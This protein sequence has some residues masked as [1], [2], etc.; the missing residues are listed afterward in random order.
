MILSSRSILLGL[1][2]LTAG[3]LADASAAVP[4][5]AA[6]HR[7]GG[8]AM[9]PGLASDL[10]DGQFAMSES[11]VDRAADYFLRAVALDPNNP[12]LIQQA[13]V[14]CLM[15]D[16]PDA[17]R[18][19]RRLPENP[20]ALLLLADVDAKAGNWDGAEAKFRALPRQGVTQ[21]L[22][23][24]LIAWALQGGGHTDAALSSLRPYVEGQRFRAVYALHAA[25][26]AD[27]ANRS[28]DAARYYRIAQTDFGGT[29]LRLAQTIASW[30]AREGHTAEAEQTLRSVADSASDMAIALPALIANDRHR[31]VAHATDGIAEAYLAL[32]AA[33]ARPD[34]VAAA[35]VRHLRGQQEPADGTR[36]AGI[37]RRGRSAGRRGA[38]APCGAARHDGQERR[39]GAR[40]RPDRARLS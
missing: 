22:Q 38:D 19:A 1:T 39:C 15:A 5:H 2:M 16:R 11:D 25:L 31:V 27:L 8:D 14:A 4:R 12:D 37:D 36:R 32:A 6:A 29:N 17:V 26:I 3:A 10:L 40:P 35:A 18:L 20:A 7:S 34:A 33:E 9:P 13:F 24:L 23:P 30:Q 28:A 21:F